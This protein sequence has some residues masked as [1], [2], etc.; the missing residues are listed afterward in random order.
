MGKKKCSGCNVS[1]NTRSFKNLWLGGGDI[2]KMV[3]GKPFC[4]Y[5]AKQLQVIAKPKEEPVVESEE[6]VVES[7]EP[8]A[9]PGFTEVPVRK[10]AGPGFIEVPIHKPKGF[11]NR[12]EEPAGFKEVEE[13]K[14]EEPKRD[15]KKLKKPKAEVVPAVQAKA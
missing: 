9:D 10:E 8:V 5:C 7:E 12:Q 1:L 11:V 6:P 2:I 15:A 4:V 13:P 3:K 14:K